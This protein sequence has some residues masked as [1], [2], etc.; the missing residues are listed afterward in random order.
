MTSQQNKFQMEKILKCKKIKTKYMRKHRIYT[1]SH[2][3]IRDQITTS[4]G[5]K[6]TLLKTDNI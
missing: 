3:S 5:G 4:L 1:A 2:D 6:K